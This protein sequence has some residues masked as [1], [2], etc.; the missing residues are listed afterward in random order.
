MQIII[1]SFTSFILTF[2]IIGKLR[3]FLTKIL[4]D[5]PNYRS[6]HNKVVSR[7]GGIIFFF[8]FWYYFFFTWCAK[9]NFFYSI[10]TN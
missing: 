9:C 10:S 2:L 6:D 7:A 3:V 8:Y 4:P 1:F 5:I